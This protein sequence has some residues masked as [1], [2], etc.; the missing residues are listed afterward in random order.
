MIKTNN[1]HQLPGREVTSDSL[2]RNH[3]EAAIVKHLCAALIDAGV[4]GLPH[5]YIASTISSLV[6]AAGSIGIISPYSQ[7]LKTIRHQLRLER[8]SQLEINTVDKYQGPQ[9]TF[10][11]GDKSV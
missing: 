1:T 9:H 7:Q 4:P 8:F 6:I 10:L 11:H 2:V 5:G 3:V